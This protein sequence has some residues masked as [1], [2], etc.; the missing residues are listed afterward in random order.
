MSKPSKRRTRVSV[1]RWAPSGKA[2]LLF[3]RTLSWASAI[4]TAEG[5]TRLW[6]EL[7]R[8]G[9]VVKIP[10]RFGCAFAYEKTSAGKDV[11]WEV[12]CGA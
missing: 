8:A 9:Y 4:H 10:A 5:S 6:A 11:V 2:M 3:G 1:S 7:E 12:I